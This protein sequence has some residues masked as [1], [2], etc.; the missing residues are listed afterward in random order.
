MT[1]EEPVRRKISVTA[2]FPI[3]LDSAARIAA[4]KLRIS[5]AELV[6]RAVEYYLSRLNID[7]HLG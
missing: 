1:V 7:K 2:P 5:R 3:E 4:A 6:R